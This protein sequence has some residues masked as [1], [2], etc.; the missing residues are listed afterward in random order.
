VRNKY[1]IKVFLDKT[2]WIYLTE[3]GG[4]MFEVVPKLFKTRKEAEKYSELFN[5]IEIVRYRNKNN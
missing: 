3:A 4:T 2:D 5:N 1:A